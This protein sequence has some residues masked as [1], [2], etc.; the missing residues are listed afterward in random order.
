M[1]GTT[2]K[3]GDINNDKMKIRNKDQNPEFMSKD[4]ANWRGPIYFNRKDPRIGVPKF[5]S[6]MGWTFNM[7]NPYSYL[8]L[9][10]FIA[11]ILL[12]AFHII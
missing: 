8:I 11:V 2:S 10:V 1:F 9:I 12:F 7:A 3:H 4:M 6:T 5:N